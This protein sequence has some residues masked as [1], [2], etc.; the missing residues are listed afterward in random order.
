MEAE[1]AVKPILQWWQKEFRRFSPAEARARHEKQLGVWRK[2]V[3]QAKS[4]GF[5]PPKRPAA[6]ED[7]RASRHR[8]ACLYNGMVAPLIPFSIRGV[9]CY[10]GL[11]NLFWADYSAVL[12]EI[13]IRDWRTRWAKGDFPVGMVQPAPYDCSRWPRSGPDA[14]SVQREAQLIVHEKVANIG[15]APTMD[16]DAVDVLHFTAKQVVGRRLAC[17]A[18]A[19]VYGLDI[20]HAGPI[21]KSMTVEGE[22]VRV[23]FRHTGSG[24]TTGDGRPPSHFEVAG[25]DGEYYR[26]AARIDGHTVVVQSDRVAK[27]IA[28]RFAFTD[29][30]V[31]NLMNREGLPA[32]LFRTDAAEDS[33]IR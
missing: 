3:A 18:L 27:P 14:Y 24:L 5:Q 31:V 6:P 10:Q 30:A 32:S 26:G 16:V 12:L 20:P 9:I 19:A 13:M 21:Y 11:G 17:W 29:T 28:V 25:A 2:A 22:S 15:I 7:P 23:R 8:P 4:R 33:T 1:S